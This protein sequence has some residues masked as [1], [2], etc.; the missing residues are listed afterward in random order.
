MNW[1]KL[2]NLENSLKQFLDRKIEEEYL[3]SE[4]DTS[5]T[6]Q[7]GR[8]EDSNW[9]LPCVVAYVESETLE[10]FEIGS[11]ARNEQILMIIDIYA[12]NEGERLDIVSWVT[13]TINDGFPYYIYYYNSANPDGILKSQRSWANIN[14]LTNTRVNLGQNVSEIDAHR[15]RISISVWTSKVEK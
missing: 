13:D 5:I 3:T 12:R 14:F 6:V 4:N 2:R 7:V 11:N 1:G 9:V 10:R 15:H 8:K